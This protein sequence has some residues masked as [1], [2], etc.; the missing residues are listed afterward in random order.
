MSLNCLSWMLLVGF[1]CS[2]CTDYVSQIEDKIEESE[3]TSSVDQ[4]SSSVIIYCSS[5]K[6]A[7]SSDSVARSSESSFGI[8]SVEGSLTDSRDGQTYKTVKI[9]DQ[10]WMAENLNYE[11][12][13]SYCYND[14]A[15]DCSKYGRLYIWAAA[16]SVCPAGWHLPS[17][18]EWET[19]FGFVGEQITAGNALKSESGWAGNGDGSDSFS[20]S[21]LPAGYR[22][23]DGYYR[24]EGELTYFWSSTEYDSDSAY[25]VYL[26]YGYD[27]ASLNYRNKV[28]WYSVRCLKDDKSE[29]TQKFSSS[30]KASSSSVAKSSSSVKSSSSSRVV[31]T[32]APDNAIVNV[33]DQVSWTFTQNDNVSP[34][35]LARASYLWTFDGGAPGS[36]TAVGKEGL[37]QNVTYATSGD[38]VASLEF[39]I[40]SG[41]YLVTC[42]PVHVLDQTAE[43]SSSSVATSSSSTSSSSWSGELMMDSRD[44]QTYKIVK[45][46]E[47][48]WMA[49]NLNYETENSYCY[50]DSASYCDKYG[51]LY[52]WAAAM[53]S[54]GTWSSN[55]KGCGCYE[56]DENDSGKKCLSTYPVRGVCPEG[57][58]LPM[59]TEMRVLLSAVG[60]DSIAGK[61]LKSTIGWDNDGNGSDAFSFSAFPAGYTA[62]KVCYGY[63]GNRRTDFLSST[64]ANYDRA[65]TMTLID[66]EEKAHLGAGGKACGFSVRCLMDDAS[67]KVPAPDEVTLGIMTDNRDN[68]T[69]KT[70]KIGLQT[71]MAENMN[72]KIDNSYCYNDSATYCTKYGR[73]YTWTAAMEACPSGWHLPTQADWEVLFTACGLK[74]SAGKVLKSTSGW[75]SVGNGTD[76]IAFSA[77]PAGNRRV[78]GEYYGLGEVTFFWSSIST[79]INSAY[80]IDLTNFSSSTGFVG[81]SKDVAESVRCVKD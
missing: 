68:Q 14:S 13:D 1:L 46:G 58:H 75:D 18:T 4:S 20:F 11:T 74:G 41:S 70:A 23:N 27:F 10:T 71:W 66:I 36:A 34:I 72:Y 40:A 30:T 54:A 49:E 59:L 35:Q 5:S 61:V 42:S 3:Q 15:S 60:G 47:Q 29:Q 21:S 44:G 48:T 6:V 78:T 52:T 22:N 31:G 33:G 62:N 73:L 69:Y 39:V 67:S 12:A 37:S 32:C 26:Y 2:A 76:A 25:V 51:R 28:F 19:L 57:W 38:Y 79:G 50:K 80:E 81:T 64:E 55:G 77:L 8:N 24:S 65:Y 63:E 43:S 16:K 45:I 7:K 17:K 53:D 56:Y 9:G